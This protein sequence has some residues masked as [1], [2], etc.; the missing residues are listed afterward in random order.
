MPLV[1][2]LEEVSGSFDDDFASD[3]GKG[4][5][6][7]TVVNGSDAVVARASSFA[8]SRWVDSIICGAA[9]VCC[10]NGSIGEAVDGVDA[11][12]AVDAGAVVVGTV[13]VGTADVGTVDVAA[14][15]VS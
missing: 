10:A 6:E 2:T 13:D 4:L 11:L 5:Y 15:D 8:S 7:R 12:S 1:A 3:D 9:M 14:V